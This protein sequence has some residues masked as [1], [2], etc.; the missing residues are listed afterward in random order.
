MINKIDMNQA[1]EDYV[2]GISSHKS[3]EKNGVSATS[4][5]RELKKLGLTRKYTRKKLD[6]PLSKS[7]RL[8]ALDV[9]IF[10]KRVHY[11]CQ[12]DCG[13]KLRV[14]KRDYGILTE[15]SLQ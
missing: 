11:A 1:I 6:L 15:W 7:G 10:D 9:H 14:R 12:C 4:L 8:T 5:V 3:A 2:S 13:R